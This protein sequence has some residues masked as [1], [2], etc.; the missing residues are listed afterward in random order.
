[1]KKI[2][3][4]ALPLMA[5][6]FVSC[7]KGNG[8]DGNN[9]QKLVKEV[10]WIMTV[11]GN[12][13]E[14]SYRKY[15]YDS[16]NRVIQITS[17]DGFEKGIDEFEYDGNTITVSYKWLDSD[18]VWRSGDSERYYLDNNGYVIKSEYIERNNNE[19]ET[20]AYPTTYEYENGYLTMSEYYTGTIT[21]Y[22]WQN[23]DIVRY[24]DTEIEYLDIE[25]KMNILF[26][27]TN[28]SISDVIKF[29]GTWSKHL[30]SGYGSSY[31]NWYTVTYK[32]DKDGYPT[33]IRVRNGDGDEDEFNIK[34]Y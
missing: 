5:V 6:C 31:E 29:P 23:G 13:S 10:S 33:K 17:S 26:V 3:L 9:G 2:L 11:D 15:K 30:I 7:E 19:T 25:N 27:D 14:P 21:E 16:Q 1:M 20:I 12:P 22:E 8:Y 18:G 4:L 24:G 34:Y 28:H 32:F